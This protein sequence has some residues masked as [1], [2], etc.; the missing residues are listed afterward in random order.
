MEEFKNFLKMIIISSILLADICWLGYSIYHGKEQ[1]W[2][3]MNLVSKI[4]LFIH[5]ILSIILSALLIYWLWF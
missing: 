5:G 4:C 1:Q 3:C 2:I